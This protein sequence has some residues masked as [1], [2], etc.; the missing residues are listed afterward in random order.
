MSE[1]EKQA[2]VP[3]QILLVCKAI[4]RR[5]Q[6]WNT[7]ILKYSKPFAAIVELESP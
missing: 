6:F 1:M 4:Y 7:F 2:I 3:N 5:D